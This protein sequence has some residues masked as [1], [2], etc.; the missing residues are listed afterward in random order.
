MWP[1]PRKGERCLVSRSW[2][3]FF[4]ILPNG[5]VSLLFKYLLIYSAVLGLSCSVQGLV[6]QPGMEP[7][8]P[9]WECGV[10]RSTRGKS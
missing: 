3:F 4:K 5:A 6:P 9:C 7:G 10:R 1:G 8:L 2:L